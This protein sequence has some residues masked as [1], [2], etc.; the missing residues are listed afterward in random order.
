[1]PKAALL[2]SPWCIYAAYEYTH[3]AQSAL[4]INGFSLGLRYNFGGTL[5]DT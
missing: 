4:N 3:F 5:K 1:M 2:D